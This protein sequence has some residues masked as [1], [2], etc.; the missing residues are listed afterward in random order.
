MARRYAREVAMKLFYQKELSGQADIDAVIAM[1]ADYSFNKRDTEYI[2]YVLKKFE[3]NSS[4]IDNYIK[5]F[6]KDWSFNRIAKVDLAILRLAICEILYCDDIPA[7]VS[8]NE[9][10][11]LA[12]K[13]SGE[14]AGKFING[15]LGSLVR[16]LQLVPEGKSK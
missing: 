10:I 13:Y 5:R 12:K 4:E 1:D 2:Q 11:E 7:C 9:G 6:V 16:S 14:K 3:E 8:I 15:I